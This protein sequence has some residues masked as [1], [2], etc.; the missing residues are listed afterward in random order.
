MIRLLMIAD[1]FTG[2]LDTGVQLA[3]YGANTRVV[4]DPNADLWKIGADAQVLVL[5]AETRHLPPKNAY[6]VVH[7]IVAQAETMGVP[8]LYKKTDSALRGNI[9][10][11]LEAVLQAGNAKQ[12]FFFPAFPQ[13]GRCTVQGVHYIQGVPVAQS[14][15]GTDPFEPVMQSGVA[16]LIALQSS[17]PVLSLPPLRGQTPLPDTSGVLVFDA[18]T[19]DDLKA[20]G[21]CLYKAGRLHLMAGCAGFAAQLPELL[22]IGTGHAPALPTLAPK[23][24]VLCGSVNPITTAQLDAAEQAGFLRLRMTP[25]QKLTPGYWQTDAGNAQLTVWAKEMEHANHCILDSNDA[26]GNEATADYAQA[27]GLTLQQVRV[28]I[29]GALGQ[30]LKALNSTGSLGTLLITGGDTLLQCMNEIGVTQMEPLGEL[31]SG[32]VVSRFV[33]EGHQR[34]VISKSGGFG[35]ATLMTDLA[36]L[37]QNKFK[38]E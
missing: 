7:R 32:V 37:L 8:F 31:A 27:Q 34:Y 16:E 21:A 9:G 2:A 15:F 6:Q 26:E 19:Q 5:D 28:R 12:V 3:A 17:A 10:A 14:V 1:D 36:T 25:E 13:M 33:L 29:S 20:T 18:E 11:E 24:L 4:T 35:A 30:V 23:L 22:G 38:G